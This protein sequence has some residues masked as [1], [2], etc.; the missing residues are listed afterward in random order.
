M[1]ALRE[2]RRA[3]PERAQRIENRRLATALDEALSALDRQR[4]ELRAAE[5]ALG[6]EVEA[7]ADKAREVESTLYSG[8]VT[9]PK[10]LE[11]LQ[12]EAESLRRRQAG[13]EE[14]E[15]ALMEEIDAVEA[16]MRANQE[17]RAECDRIDA[18]LDGAI[19]QV[20]GEI[21]SELA[22]LAAS[23]EAAVGVVP[24]P[25]LERYQTLRGNARLNGLAA[26]RLVK[27]T[28]QAC[29]LKLP[30]LEHHKIISQPE[31]ALVLCT[32]CKRILV[33]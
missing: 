19:A 3:L 4:E 1:V 15:L 24:M 9:A 20:E 31:D 27:G 33:R 10:E 6:D 17:R 32:L 12:A 18:S 8:S 16:E 26:A 14:R 21:D 13:L 22:A 25:V 29:H 2:K 7:A 23:R 28:C 30:V 11:A 5:N